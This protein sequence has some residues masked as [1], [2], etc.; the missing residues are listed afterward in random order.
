[1]FGM[2]RPR[3]PY[4][5]KETSRH[6]KVVWYFRRGKEKRIR[7]PGAYDSPEFIEAYNAALAGRPVETKAKAPQTSLRWLVDQYLESGRF[8]K[9][10][11]ETQAMRKRV[12]LNVCQTGGDL[13]FRNINPDDIQRGK[14]R[15]EGTPYAAMNYVKIMRALF[16][17][18]VD[19]TWM[20]TNPAASISTK[21]PKSDG[22]HTWTV[23]E[24]RQFMDHHPVGTQARLALDIFIYTGLRREDAVVLGKQHIRDGIITFRTQK[25]GIEVVIPLLPALARSIEATETGDLAL[26]CTSRGLPW[27]KGSF[28][29][30]FADQCKAAG[31][32]GRAHGLRKAGATI[33]AQNGATE[34]QLAAM[35]GWT[36]SRMAQTY[37]RKANKRLL[38]EQA[39]NALSPH[40]EFGAGA[41]P[42]KQAKSKANS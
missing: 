18:A 10:A 23:E 32:P 19:S 24:V 9:L 6:G 31:V 38:A 28:G 15:R 20:K 4:I 14:M 11:G 1:M 2:P 39:A 36:D 40:L 7:L 42:E 16:E 35:Y 8:G 29:T 26:L 27:A 13:N 17:F 41:S 21:V 22:H 34:I 33:A 37:T 30:W 12:L 5:Q 3:K 25:G